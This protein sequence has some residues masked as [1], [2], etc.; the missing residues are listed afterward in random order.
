[1]ID[2]K[3][4]INESVFDEEDILDDIDK[5]TEYHKW[6]KLLT[7]QDTFAD[8]FDKLWMMI[9]REAKVVKKSHI[10]TLSESNIYIIF[11]KDDQTFSNKFDNYQWEVKYTLKCFTKSNMER[12]TVSSIIGNIV[13]DNN[14]KKICKKYYH[15]FSR[16][17]LND[18]LPRT[19]HF[20]KI[21]GRQIYILP[22]KYKFIY[23]LLFEYCEKSK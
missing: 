16:S 21:I 1:M 2:L 13:I 23:K 22:E 4:Y 8:A 6:Y 17:Q 7:N 19:S 11:Q 3:S 12:Y 5:N 14:H 18:I 15:D 20:N 9:G 10:P